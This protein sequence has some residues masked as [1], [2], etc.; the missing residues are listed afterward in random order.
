MKALRGKKSEDIIFSGSDTKGKMGMASVSMVMDNRDG[1]IPIEYDEVVMTR[2]VYRSG[3]SEYLLNGSPV[4]LL[5]LQL[6]LAK[7]QFAHGSYSVIGQGTIDRLLLHSP[8]ERKEFFDEATGIKEFQIKRH[9]AWLKLVRTKE[10]VTQAELLLQEVSPRL[11]TLSRQ[12]K[13]LEERQEVEM[14]LRE[15]QEQYYTTLWKFHQDQIDGL[16]REL[17]DVNKTYQQAQS[18]LLVIQEELAGLAK[19]SSRQDAF[20]ELQ[21]K[22]ETAARQKHALERE[23]AVISG[24]LH[25]EY[26]KAGQQNVGW[27]QKKIDELKD[28]VGGVQSE[29]ERAEQDASQCDALFRDTK[30]NMEAA[31]VRRTELRGLIAEFQ[32]K[33]M[34]QKSGEAV[35]QFTG[36]RAVQAI[37]E[38]RHEFGDV[39]G[40]VAQLGRVG[41]TYQLALDVA[42][43]SHLS[44]VIVGSD[45]VAGACIEY[46]RREQLGIA[47]FLPLNKMKPRFAPQDIRDLLDRPGVHGLAVDL[48]T[49]DH[50]YADVFSYIFGNT[51]VVEDIATAREIGIGRIRMVTLAGD[52]LETSGSMRGGF[53]RKQQ[54]GLSFGNASLSA[55]A[56]NSEEQERKLFTLQQDF[57]EVEKQYEQLQGELGRVQSAH[58]MANRMVEDLT[59]KKQ[60]LDVEIASLSQELSLLHMDKDEYSDV[61]KGFA[62]EQERITGEIARAEE[63]LKAI[64]RTIAKFNEEEEEKKKRVFALQ[65]AMQKEQE[66]LNAL[67]AIKNEKEISIAK[68]D[69]KQEDLANEVFQ[70]M[71][72]SIESIVTRNATLLDPNALAVAQEHIQKLK[73]QLSLIGGIDEDVVKEFTETKERHDTLL[74]QVEDLQ[75]AMNDLETMVAE[76]DDFMKKKRDKAFKM[77]RKEF[78]RYFSILF[79]GGTADITEVYGEEKEEGEDDV[80][81]INED[82]EET[83]KKKKKQFLVGIDVIANPPGKKIKNLQALSGGE[84]TMTSIALVCAI[85]HTNPSPFVVLD[86]VEAA[87]DEANTL[88][89]TNILQ[90]LATQS[91]FI[92]ITH[93][94]VT[95]HTADAL[96]GVTMGADGISKLLSVKL[97]Q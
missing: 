57:A 52:V 2:R 93:N 59:S 28:A 23:Q 12:V 1:R 81:G 72:T 92:L 62:A 17:T 33:I 64:E 49:F 43:G 56:G 79:D 97:K 88:R 30:K 76:L 94:K 21:A 53:R 91:Q 74:Q 41:D 15:T 78:A 65:D 69:T 6:L 39:Y 70:E 58:H 73:Y 19:A 16:H 67:L 89:F 75:K 35:M 42:A 55:Y 96:Y 20:R 51:L 60:Q 48:V 13:K 14:E 8:E 87:L 24:K 36:L 71:H 85:L 3:E 40:A 38:A 84:R 22:F 9:Q 7:A 83:Q 95:M 26:S 63:D 90:E 5:D 61:M 54:S 4:R 46:L 82:G 18:H 27:L 44:S 34:Q 31:A 80:E 11:K 10:N 77:I 68:L 50:K 86:E 29:L 37:L 47:T 66:T 25:V 45:R 32:H